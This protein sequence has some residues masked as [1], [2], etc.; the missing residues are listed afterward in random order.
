MIR[1][2]IALA[3][4]AV[5]T[6]VGAASPA[7]QAAPATPTGRILYVQPAGTG[8]GELRSVRPG[9]TGDFGYG[10][11]VPYYPAADYSA[12]GTRIAY[13]GPD[14]FSIYTMSAADGSDAQH[15][16]DGPCGPSDPQWSPDGTWISFESCGD[17]YEFKATGAANGHADIAPGGD[18]LSATWNPAG[19]KVAT[20]NEQVIRTY[21]ADGSGT[22]T[23]L[24]P[25]PGA[26]HLDWSPNG[27]T[28]AVEADGDLWLVNARTGAIAR[29]TD[30][31]DATEGNPVWSPD[32]RWLAY[33]RATSGQTPQIWLITR[34]G[35]RAHST[36]VAG[37]PQSWRAAA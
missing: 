4:G 20:A 10:V 14:F 22:A 23:T 19:T 33:S 21:P 32:G 35:A 31:P 34:G 37:V 25:L 28:I 24:A 3:T 27:R 15:I 11:Q 29:L 26:W 30:T 7:A 13:L 17:I 12:D 8:G 36:A 1:L 2:H 16:G 6:L 18:N 9:G 5:V